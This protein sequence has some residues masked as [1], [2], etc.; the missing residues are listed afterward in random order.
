MSQKNNLS[1]PQK[2]GATGLALA[3]MV[4]IATP[5][6]GSWEGKRNTPYRDVVGVWTVCYGET[7]NIDI[8]RRYSDAE[9]DALHEKGVAEFGKAVAKLSPEIVE[10]P[11][12]WAAH[13]SIA[14]NIGIGAYRKSSMRR[15]FNAGDHRSACRAIRRY[16]YAGG[17]VIKGLQLRRE[18]DDKRVGEYELCLFGVKPNQ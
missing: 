10:Y 1:T 17:R 8:N 5:F 6:I 3:A 16:K 11:A 9:C 12:Q 7:R 18:G 14:Y 13:T 2:A 4:A 15:L